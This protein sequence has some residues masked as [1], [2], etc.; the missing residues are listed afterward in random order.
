MNN[1]KRYY[2]NPPIG[3][4]VVAFSKNW[5]TDD[6]TEGHKKGFFVNVKNENHFITTKWN[7]GDY[8]YVIES[9]PEYWNLIYN[10]YGN[11]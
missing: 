1:N 10:E 4:T 11:L 2:E 6:N 8:D 3:I 5:I 9:L 7:G